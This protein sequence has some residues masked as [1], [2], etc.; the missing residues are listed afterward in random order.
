[1]V[2]GAAGQTI[3]RA[4]RKTIRRAQELRR[5]LSPPEVSLWSR[6]RERASGKPV[7]RRQHPIGPY[8]LDFYCAKARL[9]IEL[10]GMSHDMGDRPQRDLRRDE[11]LKAR[12]ITVM[13]IPAI[14]LTHGIDEAGDAIVRMAMDLL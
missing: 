10:D 6:L 13:R 1:V 5:A 12:G 2:E 11:W 9:A 3:V 7:F 4:P 14:D 8:V